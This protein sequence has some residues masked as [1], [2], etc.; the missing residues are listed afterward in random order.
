MRTDELPYLD[1][2]TTAVAADVDAVWSVLIETVEQGF[3][4]P[5]ATRYARIVGCTD[6]AVSGPR[7]LAEGSTM[8]GFRVTL[9]IPESGLRLEGGHRFSSYA[10]IFRLEPIGPNQ[11]L[12]RAES[13]ADFPGLAGGVYRLLVVGT[14]GH[15]IAVRRFLAGIKRR[16][17]PHTKA[18]NGAA[19]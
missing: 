13:R 9:A 2:H 7:P 16:V 10:F 3:S 4:R 12:L 17:E 11:S 14:G 8:P 5:S 18:P 15:A 19:R 6:Q 1:E